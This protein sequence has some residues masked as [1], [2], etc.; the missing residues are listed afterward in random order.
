MRGP[1]GDVADSAIPQLQRLASAR[2]A[3]RLLR[4]VTMIWSDSWITDASEPLDVQTVT[5]LRSHPGSRYTLRYMVRRGNQLRTV[6]AKVYA[7]DRGDV[8]ATLS[9]ISGLGFGPGQHLQAALPLAYVSAFRLLLLEEAPGDPARAALCRGQVGVGNAAARWLVAFHATSVPLP[10]AYRMHDPLIKAHRW[11][12]ALGA[13]VPALDGEARRLLT[14]LV[15][16]Q[17]VWPPAPHL[18]HGD[19]GASHLY[20]A[21]E[22]IT[23]IDWDAWHVGDCAADA[24]R[25]LASLYHLAGRDELR[26]GAIAREAAIFAMVYQNA[27]PAAGR[28]LAFHTALACLRKAERLM[29]DRRSRNTDRAAALLAAGERAVRDRLGAI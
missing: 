2:D 7:R 4:A 12:A 11:A 28:R 9:L 27:L 18:V 15:A 20:L 6:I 29:A 13:A 14:A 16:A 23:A 10:S 25:F 5:L 17:P 1:P 19:F 24:G 21:P 26:H 8:A 3:T 22:A